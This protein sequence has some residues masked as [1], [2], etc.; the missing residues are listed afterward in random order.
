M[1]AAGKW[2]TEIGWETIE[3]WHTEAGGFTKDGGTITVGEIRRRCI[4][5]CG[6]APSLG[7]IS[8][9]FNEETRKKIVERTK[10]YRSTIEG[11]IN[12]RL[13][14]FNDK[15]K[16]KSGIVEML[17]NRYETVSELIRNRLKDVKGRNGMESKKYIEYWKK[18]ENLTIVD[19]ELEWR[20]PCKICGEEL[21]INPKGENM[22]LD[23]IVPHTRGGTSELSNIVPVHKRCN[24]SKTNMTM[25][26]MVELAKKVV[27]THG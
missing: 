9:H 11:M 3:D 7:S 18:N 6:S 13:H 24:Q 1:A 2:K 5:I 14:K 8:P 23:H 19:E 21:V 20:M 17:P 27:K 25:E 12:K 26:E 4:E 15:Y 10:K 16:M 22:Q